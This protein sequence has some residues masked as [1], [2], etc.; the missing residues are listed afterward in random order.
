M[1]RTATA[2][3]RSALCD[4]YRRNRERSRRLFDVVRPEAYY[5]R[6][7]ALRHPIVFYEGHLPAFSVNALVKKGLGRPGVDDALERLFARGIDPEDEADASRSGRTE[8]PARAEVQRF[9]EACDALVLDALANAP[10]EQPGHPLLHDAQAA[11][12]ILEHEAM[13]QET[14]LYM[15]HQLPCEHK[16]APAGAAPDVAGTTPAPARVTVPAGRATLG[17]RP[18]EIPF[19][20]DNE[21]PGAVVEVP[22]FEIDVHDVTNEQFLAFVDAGG[23]QR[24]ELWTPDAFAWVQREGIAHPRFWMRHDGAWRWRGMFDEFDLPP[25][26]P[27]Y[28]SQAEAAA[29]A[30]W[31]EGR[32]P[33]EAEYHRAAFGE[34]SGRERPYPW[35]EARP[36]AS[37]GLFDFR[38]WSPAAVGRHPAGQSAWDVHDLMGNGWEWTS[39][40]FAPFDG[41]RPMASYPEY[42]ADFFDGQHLVM[43]GA[44]PAT[45]AALLRRSFRNW[46]RPT[47]PFVYAAFRCVRGVE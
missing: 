7:I 30:R 31:A 26:W 3:D 23:Y 20:W 46:F 25:A 17:A 12:A 39:T 38:S 33:T 29:Y 19:G 40:V 41:F 24:P 11:Y 14:M 35:G 6:P 4:W 27:V 47:Y 15:W 37:R 34:P 28:V 5:S 44:S 43:K 45:D 16:Q 1:T 22:A 13:H 18:G 9:A 32:L 36:D 2:L 10:I 21:F 8:W 42:S